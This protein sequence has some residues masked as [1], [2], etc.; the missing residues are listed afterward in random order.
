M[1]NKTVLIV[2]D[3]EFFIKPIRLFLEKNGFNVETALDGMKGLQQ[4]RTVNPDIIMLDLMLPGVDGFQIC[5]MLKGDRKFK[6][7][8]VI[9]VSAKDTDHDKS[10]G[11]QSGADFYITKPV[12]PA[13]L[14]SEINS[15]LG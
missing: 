8:P 9:I 4:A 10:L 14:L 3:E 15:L 7:I 5:R 1:A 2:D 13:T 6:H 11:K 12:V